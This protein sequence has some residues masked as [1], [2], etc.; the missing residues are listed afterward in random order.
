MSLAL[1]YSVLRFPFILLSITLLVTQCSALLSLLLITLLVSMGLINLIILGVR[2]YLLLS[3]LLLSYMYSHYNS[4]LY[5]TVILR[6]S[7]LLLLQLSALRRTPLYHLL[8]HN[9]RAAQVPTLGSHLK[10]DNGL[11]NAPRYAHT[12][13]RTYINLLD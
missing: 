13:A 6:V 1:F 2:S 12:R 10:G 8:L 7:L 11:A 5:Y 9:T 4:L 3:L